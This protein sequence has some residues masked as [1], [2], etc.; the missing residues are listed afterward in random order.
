[1][2]ETEEKVLREN[3]EAEEQEIDLIELAAKLWKQRKKIALWGLYGA[4]FGLIV[5]F[6]IPRE[7]TATIKL[8]PEVTDGKSASGSLGALAA[9][10]GIGGTGGSGADAVYPQ[11]YPD[12]VHSTPFAVGLFTLPVVDKDKKRY[13]LQQYV[14]E[15]LSAP[16]WSFIMGLPGKALGALRSKPAGGE[17]KGIDA[18]ELTQ[19]QNAVKM[20]LDERISANVDTKTGV[21]TISATMQDPMV[22]AL[23]VDSVASRLKAYVTDYRTNKARE[24]LEYAEKLN[25]EA[26]D[27]YYKAQQRYADYMDRNQGLALYGA[28]TTRDRLQNEAQLAF[29]LYNQTAQQLQQAEAKVQAVR[30]VFAT[31]EPPTVPLKPSKPRKVLILIG[32]VFLACVIQCAWILFGDNIRKIKE[33]VKG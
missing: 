10:A 13:E 29:T 15:E 30:P 5:A 28:Q 23:V 11:L 20:V 4:I 8:A 31:I 27:A 33:D 3:P 9:M 32:C 22:A 2:K 16:W 6:S 18:F 19:E 7:Y 12:V 26:R 1:M 25:D 14:D 21:V 17:G 24:D